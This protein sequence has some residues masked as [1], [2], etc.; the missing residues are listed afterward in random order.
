MEAWRGEDLKGDLEVYEPSSGPEV[1]NFVAVTSKGKLNVCVCDTPGSQLALE[2]IGS[3]DAA[4]AMFDCT[5]RSTY[6]SI[7]RWYSY[8]PYHI[9]VAL[10]GNKSNEGGRVIRSKDITFHK[11]VNAAVHE[12]VMNYYDISVA[13]RYNVDKPWTWICRKLMKDNHLVVKE[14]IS[15]H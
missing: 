3:A 10:C 14:I 7:S 11:E 2:A 12:T 15:T 1:Y 8:L 6:D 9:P 5:S 4:V 13:S